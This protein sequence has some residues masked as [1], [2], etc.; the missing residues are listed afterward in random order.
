MQASGA[1]IED[2]L[3]GLIKRMEYYQASKFACDENHYALAHLQSAAEELAARRND[4]E[5]GEYWG[6]TQSNPG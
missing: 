4:R 1:F 6:Y 2:V 3:L 5:I